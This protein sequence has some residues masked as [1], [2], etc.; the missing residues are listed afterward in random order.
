MDVNSRVEFDLRDLRNPNTLRVN[1]VVQD[2]SD[3]VKCE[4]TRLDS[5]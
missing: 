2:G 4:V 5:I 1:N 3:S